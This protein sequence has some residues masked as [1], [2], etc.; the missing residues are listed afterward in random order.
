[1]TPNPPGTPIPI[2]V[3]RLRHSSANTALQEKR[4]EVHLTAPREYGN[5]AMNVIDVAVFPRKSRTNTATL[6][7]WIS[8]SSESLDAFARCA[9]GEGG[10]GGGVLSR[11]MEETGP[12]RT[13][14]DE[15]SRRAAIPLSSD[16][17]DEDS[18]FFFR[19]DTLGTCTETLT[20]DIVEAQVAGQRRLE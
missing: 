12:L 5:S 3:S 4:N 10:V 1:M 14:R 20:R 8:S 9:G 2:V 7:S 6:I 13:E 19:R 15:L 16:D 18:D 11:W 17:G